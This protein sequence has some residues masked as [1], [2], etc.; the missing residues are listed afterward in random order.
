[1]PATC[2]LRRLYATVSSLADA[3]RDMIFIAH[4]R[5]LVHQGFWRLSYIPRLAAGITIHD[6]ADG[7]PS[8]Y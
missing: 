7:S 2:P 3:L 1:M 8:Q 6:A 5:A 4:A